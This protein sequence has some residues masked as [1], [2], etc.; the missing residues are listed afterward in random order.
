MLLE[1]KKIKNSEFEIKDVLT[2]AYI[3]K[4]SGKF[5]GKQK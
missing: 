1:P 4:D 2:K 5:K 3:D